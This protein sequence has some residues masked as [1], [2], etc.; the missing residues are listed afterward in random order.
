MKILYKNEEE[1]LAVINIMY[2]SY[3]DN[4]T[5][6]PEEVEDEELEKLAKQGVKVLFSPTE[7]EEEKI[8][9]IYIL[10]V[11]YDVIMVK[12]IG[13]EKAEEIIRAL[14]ETNKADLTG[15]EVVMDYKTEGRKYEREGRPVF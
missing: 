13:K 7:E 14:Y 11:D 3:D 5:D 1:E 12:N 2:A 4:L 10:S 6:V 15:Y 9:G 8:E